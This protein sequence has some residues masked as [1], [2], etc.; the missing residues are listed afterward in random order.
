M[1]ITLF[2]CL[3]G[4]VVGWVA[5][6]SSVPSTKKMVTDP[7]SCRGSEPTKK[8]VIHQY[9]QMPLPH[10]S[11]YS[12]APTNKKH[13]WSAKRRHSSATLLA[14]D[15]SLP[16]SFTADDVHRA[17]QDTKAST[18]PGYEHVHMQFLK[19]WSPELRCGYHSSSLKTC[20]KTKFQKSGKRQSE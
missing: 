9:K 4:L 8:Q 12:R 5:F 1:F 7:M 15:K 10:I 16:P 2:L 20:M 11:L 13:Q 19:M 17:L 18:A 14:P 6:H 3:D